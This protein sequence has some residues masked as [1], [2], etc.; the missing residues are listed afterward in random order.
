MVYGKKMYA[1]CGTGVLCSPAQS[2]LTSLAPCSHEEAYTRMLLHVAE[3]VHKGMRKVGIRSV[4]TDVV[5]LVRASFNNISLDELS[6]ALGTGSSFWYIA[7][8]QLAAATNPRL[9]VTLP[10]FH[11]YT[12]CD[13]VSSLAGR[14]KKTTCGRFESVPRGD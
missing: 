9:C 14:G 10:T 8:F 13:T 5:V 7:V 1:T 6:I 4:D 12:G 2:D 3:A 11:A